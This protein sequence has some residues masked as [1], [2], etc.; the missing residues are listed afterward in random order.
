MKTHDQSP[1][2]SFQGILGHPP[3]NSHALTK[4]HFQDLHNSYLLQEV[5]SLLGNH[6]VTDRSNLVSQCPVIV[7]PINHN[8]VF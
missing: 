6:K 3:K 1:H 7:L 4:G 8:V 2:D 5:S